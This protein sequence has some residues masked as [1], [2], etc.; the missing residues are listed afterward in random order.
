MTEMLKNW[1]DSEELQKKI[2]QKLNETLIKNT[3]YL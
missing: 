3:I 2:G 1:K